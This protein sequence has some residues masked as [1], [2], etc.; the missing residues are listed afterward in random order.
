MLAAQCLT[1]TAG[2]PRAT[3]VLTRYATR[4]MHF[5]GLYAAVYGGLIIIKL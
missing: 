3:T 2:W 5:K 4:L 1:L